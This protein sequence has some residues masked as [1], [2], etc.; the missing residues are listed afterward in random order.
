L[1]GDGV[2]S[3]GKLFSQYVQSNLQLLLENTLREETIENI[4]GVGETIPINWKHNLGQGA[5]SSIVTD[6]EL[7]NQLSNLAIQAAQT[8]NIQFAS[9]DI[10]KTEGK[11]AVLEINSGIMMES[12]AQ[13]NKQNYQIAK[14]IYQG[15]LESILS[16]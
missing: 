10:I 1:I 15:A 16:L 13:A 12:F 7:V 11:F 4:P 9:V 2:S 8:V 3:V 6:P 14:N 5:S